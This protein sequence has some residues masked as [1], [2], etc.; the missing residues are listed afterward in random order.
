VDRP[1]HGTNPALVLAGPVLGYVDALMAVPAVIAL[2]AADAGAGW[3]AGTLATVAVFTKPQAIVA[4][5]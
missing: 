1:H 3:L 5:P 4:A 2:A